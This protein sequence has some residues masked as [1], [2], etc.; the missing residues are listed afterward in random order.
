MTIYPIKSS[1]LKLFF[2]KPPIFLLHLHHCLHLSYRPNKPKRPPSYNVRLNC[3]GMRWGLQSCIFLNVLTALA[4]ISF[5]LA[6]FTA[7]H[8]LDINT[9]AVTVSLC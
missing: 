7:V 2:M 9:F 4:S 3:Y 8:N 5:T 6:A 1:E